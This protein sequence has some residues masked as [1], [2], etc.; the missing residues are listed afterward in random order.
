MGCRVGTRQSDLTTVCARIPH[1]LASPASRLLHLG[2][3]HAHRDR[4]DRQRAAAGARRPLAEPRGTR[5]REPRLAPVAG[6]AVART[7]A[8]SAT[9]SAA[10]ACPIATWPTSRSTPG[11]PTSRPWSTSSACAAFRCSA[12][13][14]AARWRSPTRCAIRSRCRTWCS[15][16]LRPGR[17]AARRTADERLEAETLVN[18]IR[19][20]WGRDNPAFRQV[21]TNQFIPGGTPA[22]APW[23]NELERLT[24]SPEN[25][26]AP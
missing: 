18:L 20:G 12:C 25:A 15:R 11:W 5:P 1:V 6:R 26:A 4:V 3:R 7:T 10:A 2:R 9:T 13:R 21:F 16:R 24:A 8:T 19:L 22:A 14:R 17:A 23:W